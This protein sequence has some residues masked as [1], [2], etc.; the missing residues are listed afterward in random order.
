MNAVTPGGAPTRWVV[1]PTASTACLRVGHFR[2]S[3]RG[4]VPVRSGV[5]VL[6]EQGAPRSAAGTV[7][8]GGIDTGNPRRD[9][10]LRAPRLLDL[11]R[12]PGMTFTATAITGT[13][14]GWRV[15]GRAEV[16]GRA[17][18]LVFDVSRVT[19]RA[20]E[21]MSLHAAAVIDRRALGMRAP[22]FLIGRYVDVELRVRLRRAAG[23]GDTAAPEVTTAAG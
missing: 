21:T 13:D 18:P 10:D 8:L 3:V 11:D 4:T 23:A 15:A 5:L 22:N 1:E 7:D 14:S 16:R 20:G 2:G 6:D 9:R 17:I 12:Q 19:V